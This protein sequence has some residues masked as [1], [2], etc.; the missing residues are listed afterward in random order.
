MGVF[1][2]ENIGIVLKKQGKLAEAME[3]FR[4]VLRVRVATL[5]PD[6]PRAAATYTKYDPDFFFIITM[7]DSMRSG[8]CSMGNVL[9][10]QGKLPEALEVHNKALVIYLK[11][12]G[13]DH[14][15][16]ADTKVL[17][18]SFILRVFSF[19]FHDCMYCFRRTSASFSSSRASLRRPRSCTTRHWQSG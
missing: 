6:H 3:L 19:L 2:Q 8:L 9:R 12:H 16:V 4:E 14:P 15:V 1:L 7:P 17:R 11:I 13:P 5:G 10:R 18:I